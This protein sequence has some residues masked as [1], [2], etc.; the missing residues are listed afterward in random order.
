MRLFWM[1]I[2]FKFLLFFGNLCQ[3]LAQNNSTAYSGSVKKNLKSLSHTITISKSNG[4]IIQNSS[5]KLNYH[6]TKPLNA[7][8]TSVEKKS[9]IIDSY[10]K[11]V[12]P[13][14]Y[15]I[16]NELLVFPKN[17][18]LFFKNIKKN[19]INNNIYKFDLLTKN[20][21]VYN[22]EYRPKNYYIQKIDHTLVQEYSKI[23]RIDHSSDFFKNRF[24]RVSKENR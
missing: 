16:C 10:N 24:P 18:I 9:Y 17:E 15:V 19:N 4:N 7:E 1:K 21:F 6:I 12:L 3:I 22:K 23:V 14:K 13:Y 8:H 5:N 2:L 20:P 11:M